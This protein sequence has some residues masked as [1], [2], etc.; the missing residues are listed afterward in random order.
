MQKQIQFHC[1]QKERAQK[2]WNFIACIWK[3]VEK[4]LEVIAISIN[5][6]NH[7]YVGDRMDFRQKGYDTFDTQNPIT[8]K[9]ADI[10]TKNSILDPT[11]SIYKSPAISASLTPSS[12][13]ST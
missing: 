13:P 8:N 1:E 12:S 10:D 9:V 7:G 4:K 3:K 6:M 5:T 2:I 11:L